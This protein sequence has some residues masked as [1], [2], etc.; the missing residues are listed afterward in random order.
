MD[1]KI[2]DV[3]DFIDNRNHELIRCGAFFSITLDYRSY[4]DLLVD[5]PRNNILHV[6]NRKGAVQFQWIKKRDI[7]R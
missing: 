4:D 3:D 1:K 7:K 6:F 2:Y 5:K